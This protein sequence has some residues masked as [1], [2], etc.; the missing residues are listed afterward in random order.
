MYDPR[1]GP[2][3]QAHL[4]VALLGASSYTY[5]ELAQDNIRRAAPAL[6]QLGG[7]S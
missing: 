5:A 3:Q 1:G 4:F 6:L 2:V 7:G